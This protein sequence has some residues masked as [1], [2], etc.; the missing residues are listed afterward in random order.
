MKAI[1]VRPG[2]KQSIQMQD[3]PEPALGPGQA[4]IEVIRV[5]LCGTD[6]E[7]YEGLYGQAPEGSDYLILGH[8]N[9]G[10]V[11]EVSA[12]V[13]GFKPG[14]YIVASVRR[15]CAQCWSCL[16]GEPDMCSSGLYTERGIKGCH[17]YMAEFYVE[18]PEF[19]FKIPPAVKDIAVLLE[20]L[21]VVEKGIDHAFR[22]QKR[23]AWNPKTALV[24]GAGPVGL[25]AAAAAANR[26]LRTIV[27]GR[28]PETDA[29]AQV[30]P[31]LGAEY[32]SC[33]NL[34]LANLPQ[35][36]GPLDLIVECTGS[37][38]VVFTAM[39]ILAADGIL[40]LLSVTGGDKQ[41]LEPTARINQELV[42]HN[43]V[44][45]GSVNA[46][47]R[48]YR[49][50]IRDLVAIERRHPGALA[51]LITR[52]LPWTEYNAWF[53]QRAPGIKTT[54]EI[55]SECRSND[56]SLARLH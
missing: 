23:M 1:T 37:S 10:R 54:L 53:S 4:K 29:R 15:P 5:G 48:H 20:P 13:S 21:T 36:L 32:L 30:A 35:K 8:E 47:P 56:L 33:A 34:P 17:G 27:V 18:S 16:H 52:R 51:S 31:K 25:L 12:G 41:E 26:G 3:V 28:E 22:I 14:D 40:C 45:F 42:L 50:G 43:N 49:R 6:G 55:G 44:V 46:N 19:L 7:I 11:A 39:Q 38:T 9:F 2:Q 24:L